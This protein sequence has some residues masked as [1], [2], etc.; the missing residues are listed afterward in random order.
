MIDLEVDELQYPPTPES[1]PPPTWTTLQSSPR[2]PT[3]PPPPRIK[4]KVLSSTAYVKPSWCSS[5][6]Y[7]TLVT[8]LSTYHAIIQEADHE[9]KLT[10]FFDFITLEITRREQPT[11]FMLESFK[12]NAEEACEAFEYVIREEVRYFRLYYCARFELIIQKCLVRQALFLDKRR[13]SS[14]CASK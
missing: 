2:A 7:S 4:A 5:Q 3:P 12:G 14:K 1:S 13:S 6:Q 8:H 9:E 10:Q 11:P